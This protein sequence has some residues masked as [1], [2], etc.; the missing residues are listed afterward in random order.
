MSGAL[1]VV[2][3]VL[4]VALAVGASFA[5]Y[6]VLSDASIIPQA[7]LIEKLV[8]ENQDL[9]DENQ[10]LQD[11][12]E[13]VPKVLYFLLL[14]VLFLG[15]LLF[16]Y[17]LGSGSSNI[18]MREAIVKVKEWALEHHMMKYALDDPEFGRTYKRI[19]H[20]PAQKVEG[21][22]D[23]WWYIISLVNN[24]SSNSMPPDS[25]CMTYI[26]KSNDS[27]KAIGYFP[28]WNALTAWNFFKFQ[29]QKSKA[30]TDLAQLVSKTAA[31]AQINENLERLPSNG[32]DD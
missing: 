8:D 20:L 29:L 1:R 9:R 3:W 14:F 16:N 30:P 2:G 21:E 12:A 10:A 5:V 22:V 7:D 17:I 13:G 27:E 15:A 28:G 26:I 11:Q 25:E 24:W 23:S 18:T 6:K 4:L 32:G 31:A 19:H